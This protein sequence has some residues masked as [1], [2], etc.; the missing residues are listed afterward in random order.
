MTERCFLRWYPYDIEIFL[1]WCKGEIIRSSFRIMIEDYVNKQNCR[2]W[3]S[4]PQKKGQLHRPKVTVWCNMSTSR[5]MGLFFFENGIGHAFTVNS[6]RHMIETFFIVKR[7]RRFNRNMR[8][9]QDG[10]TT[11]NITMHL[12]LTKWYRSL[13]TP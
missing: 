5:F 12:F 4:A 10:A 2:Y 9:Q 11:H 6:E 3:A 1:A 13:G 8:F 7:Y